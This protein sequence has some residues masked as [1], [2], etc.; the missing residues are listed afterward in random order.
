MQTL[1]L[2]RHGI[3]ALNEQQRYCG[4]SDV[5]LSALGRRQSLLL[6]DLLRQEEFTSLYI[7]PLKRC[8][9]TIDPIAQSHALSPEPLV[10]LSEINFGLWEG[11]TF[12]EIQ[13][14][15]PDRLKA[16]CDEPDAFTFPQGEPVR[17]FR[18]RVLDALERILAHEGNSLVVAH[19]GSLR[20]IISHLC[21]WG[22]DC[23]HS[24]ALEPASSTILE[25]YQESTVVRVLNETC[26]LR[27]GESV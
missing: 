7:S 18:T 6:R 19:G 9:E 4:V 11:L 23:L 17:D 8:I 21:G 3:T 12:E 25:H 26:H 20:V 2:V 14:A 1:F 15:Y 13:S 24:F 16:W 10:G 27:I 5:C 22:M